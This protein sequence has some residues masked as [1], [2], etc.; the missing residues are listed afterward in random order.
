MGYTRK[1]NSEGRKKFRVL[2]FVSLGLV[3]TVIIIGAFLSAR[4]QGLSCPDWPLCP[5][6]FSLSPG[7]KYFIE[8]VHRVI[9]LITAVSIYATACYSVKRFVEPRRAATTTAAA[10]SFQIAIGMLVV[11]SEMHPIIVATHTGV[12]VIT[13]ALALL[14]FISTYPVF[15]GHHASRPLLK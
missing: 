13:L 9:A 14:T 2:S 3:F 12:G 7:G 5:T 6:G 11:Y 10:V 1:Q 8:Y 15:T 4:G